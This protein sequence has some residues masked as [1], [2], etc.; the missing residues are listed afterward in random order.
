MT[1]SAGA[2]DGKGG[3][4]TSI[5]VVHPERKAQRAVHR[6][7]GATRLSVDAV[8][9]VAQAAGRVEQVVPRLLIVDQSLLGSR[10]GEQLVALAAERGTT[11]CLVLMGE[12]GDGPDRVPGLF[13]SGSLTNLLVNPMPLLAEELSI[14]ALKLLRNDLFGLEKYMSWG[15]DP[16]TTVLDDAQQRSELVDALGHDVR[17]LGLGPR[18]ATLACLVAD[19]LL[20]NALYNAPVDERGQRSRVTEPRHLARPLSGREQVKIQYA[21][22]GRYLAIAVTDQYGSI[23]RSTVLGHLAKSARQGAPDKVE[24]A[25]SGAGM[26]LGLVYSCCNHLVFNIDPGKRTEVIGLIDV[27]FQ[28]RELHSQASSFNVFMHGGKHS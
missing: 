2:L 25:R 9:N 14:T 5:L 3:G 22:D 1:Q 16:A 20:S 15:I 4:L 13:T 12:A 18:I 23:E 26:G 10:E 24:F 28:P 7:L 27:R 19:E 8:D 11:A 21:C 17:E 6:I